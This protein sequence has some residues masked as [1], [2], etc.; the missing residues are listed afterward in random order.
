MPNEIHDLKVFNPSENTAEQDRTGG[1]QI[2][3]DNPDTVGERRETS[4][5]PSSILNTLTNTY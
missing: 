3:R 1:M 2:P 4:C 5:T